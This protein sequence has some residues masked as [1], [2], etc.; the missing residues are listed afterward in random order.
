MNKMFA[1]YVERKMWSM[2]FDEDLGPIRT[3]PRP[4][5]PPGRMRSMLSRFS[6]GAE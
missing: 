2:E 1:K 4:K 5:G 3:V 6:L